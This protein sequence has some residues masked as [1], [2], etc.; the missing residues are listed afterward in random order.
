MS[1]ELATHVANLQRENDRLKSEL[2]QAERLA[3]HNAAELALC[4][5][6]LYD[7][8]VQL[9]Q[10]EQREAAL[11]EAMREIGELRQEAFAATP[12]RYGTRDAHFALQLLGTRIRAALAAH[13]QAGT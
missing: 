4:G 6:K 12:V 11:V 2:E 1:G 8:Q 3:D 7:C 5:G 13:E 9:E 10:A